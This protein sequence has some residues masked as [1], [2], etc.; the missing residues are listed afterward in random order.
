MARVG[1]LD[2]DHIEQPAAAR[3]MAPNA[4]DAR[5]SSLLHLIP[6]HRRL[7]DAL[8]QAVIRWRP[9]RAGHRQDRIVAVVHPLYPQH[10][11]RPRRACVISRPLAE[12]TFQALVLEQDFA[13]K[14]DLRSGWHGEAIQ[15]A[16]QRVERDPAMPTGMGEL[17]R[18]ITDFVAGRKK[19]QRIVSAADHHR[20]RLAHLEVLLADQPAVLSRRHPQA[21]R[22]AVM[23]LRA[24]RPH[25]HPAVVGVFHDDEVGGSDVAAAVQLMQK[26]NRKLKQVD[27]FIAIDIFQNRTRLD[28]R[29]VDDV[30]VL[31]AVAVSAHHIQRALRER[32]TEGKRKPLRRVGHTREHAKARVVAGDILKKDGWRIFRLRV[33]HHLRDRAHLQL[34]VDPRHS[35]QFADPLHAFNP[36]AQVG[37]G[38]RKGAEALS[39]GRLGTVKCHHDGISRWKLGEE[40]K[41]ASMRRGRSVLLWHVVRSKARHFYRR[42]TATRWCPSRRV[43]RFH[44]TRTIP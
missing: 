25:V 19:Q 37:V 20:T 1:L 23:H 38:M 3:L 16:P 39:S 17:G 36:L 31:H 12:R 29:V 10:V 4:F 13:F 42:E 7:D 9:H 35:Q 11:I 43:R 24:I 40:S 18:A 32:E 41:P 6:D 14:H 15:F 2:G 34:P 5:Q 26:R 22:V 27:G 28:K 21:E 33:V 8:A 44:G 30:E